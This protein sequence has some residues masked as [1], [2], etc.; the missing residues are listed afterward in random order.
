M[1]LTIRPLQVSDEANWRRLWTD[2]LEY[3]E[4]EL[5]EE[6]YQSTFQ[7]LLSGGEHEFHGLI[8]ELDGRP[9]GLVHYLFHRS[10]WSIRNNCYL[11]DLFVDPQVRG[12]SIGRALIEAVYAA[13]DAAGHPNVYWQTQHF[14]DAGR[15]LYDRVGELSPFIVYKRPAAQ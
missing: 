8:A 11:Q 7:R 5:P 10:C 13:A 6:V 14:N 2:Y 12:K 3:Y 1:S 9:V 15:R 4:T